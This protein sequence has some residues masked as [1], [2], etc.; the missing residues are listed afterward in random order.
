MMPSLTYG[1]FTAEPNVREIPRCSAGHSSPD[2]ELVPCDGPSCFAVVCGAHSL[3]CTQCSRVLC[4]RCHPEITD[5]GWCLDCEDEGH[6]LLNL[7]WWLNAAEA[8][9]KAV[10][11]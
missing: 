7:G 8:S 11:A 3:C 9:R 1:R 4:D 10:A 5:T 6:Y 2:A